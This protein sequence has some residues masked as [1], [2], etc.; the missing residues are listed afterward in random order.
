MS[1]TK[2]VMAGVTSTA[3]LIGLAACGS[4]EYSATPDTPVPDDQNC[5]DW[6]WD[7][8]DAVWECDDSRSPYFGYLFFAG[9][10]FSNSSSLI[11]APGYKSYKSNLIAKQ[12]DQSTTS[13]GGS[14]GFGSGSKSYGG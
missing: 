6:E 13:S 11:K 4:E 7:E 1:K 2:K 10:Y 14:S 5:S 3:M 9:K 12:R 8:D